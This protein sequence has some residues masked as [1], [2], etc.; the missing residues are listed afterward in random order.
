MINYTNLI[1]LSID[2]ST[3]SVFVNTHHKKNSPEEKKP[4]VRQYFSIY[5][6]VTLQTKQHRNQ[7]PY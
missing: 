1:Q 6:R 5:F 3:P 7:N 2:F 4:G